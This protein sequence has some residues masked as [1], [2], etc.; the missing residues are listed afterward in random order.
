MVYNNPTVDEILKIPWLFSES[1]H[2]YWSFLPV[3]NDNWGIIPYLVYEINL[4]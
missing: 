2:I 1:N 3:T 4:R